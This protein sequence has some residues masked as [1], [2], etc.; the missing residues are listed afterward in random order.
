MLQI[1]LPRFVIKLVWKALK[2]I[3]TIDFSD[4]KTFINIVV[5]QNKKTSHSTNS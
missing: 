3:N 5:K 2:T 4:Y 1:F